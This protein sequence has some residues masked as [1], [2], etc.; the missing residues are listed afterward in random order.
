MA[1]GEKSIAFGGRT[2]RYASTHY[3]LSAVDLPLRGSVFRAAPGAASR[4]QPA[5]APVLAPSVGDARLD[6]SLSRR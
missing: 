3:L 4:Y 6:T 2:F 1:Q 5:V